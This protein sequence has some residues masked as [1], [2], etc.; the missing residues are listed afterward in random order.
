MNNNY[1]SF[2]RIE[3]SPTLTLIKVDRR[4]HV[5]KK[6]GYRYL[7]DITYTYVKNNEGPSV[8]EFAS[9]ANETFS[10]DGGEVDYKNEN[11]YCHSF[12]KVYFS[13]SAVTQIL[14]RWS[15]NE[16]TE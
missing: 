14:L 15:N 9:W 1:R 12:N 8:L 13:E 2:K 10:S 7:A 3:V 6:Y 4:D 16:T 5:C 11:Y